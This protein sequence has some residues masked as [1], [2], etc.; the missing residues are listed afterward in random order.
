MLVLLL[1]LIY[2]L[3]WHVLAFFCH[4]KNAKKFQPDAADSIRGQHCKPDCVCSIYSNRGPKWDDIAK[5]FAH[6]L[7]L[8]QNRAID[9]YLPRPVFLVENSY[10]VK[11]KEREMIWDKVAP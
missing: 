5:G 2:C 4:F 8:H 11:D 9:Y 7:A 10:V 1:L 3:L 6:L